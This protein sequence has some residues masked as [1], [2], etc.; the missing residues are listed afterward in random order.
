[1]LSVRFEERR[2]MDD[3]QLAQT[4][5]RLSAAASAPPTG[6]VAQLDRVFGMTSEEFRARVANHSM[7]ESAESNRW[8]MALDLRDGL[9]AAQAR[10]R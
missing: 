7:P 1:M 10:P 2:R 8:W 4:V 3:D 9:D 6:E 5:A